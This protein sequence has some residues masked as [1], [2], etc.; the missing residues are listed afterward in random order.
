M[1]FNPR[2]PD[3]PEENIWCENAH[4]CGS[5]WDTQVGDKF[6][7]WTCAYEVEQDRR[8]CREAEIAKQREETLEAI[9][10]ASAAYGTLG[11]VLAWE[12]CQP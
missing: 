2:M 5:R 10:L 7:C 1:T 8:L 3:E 4:D 12:G 6:L 11:A 9:R